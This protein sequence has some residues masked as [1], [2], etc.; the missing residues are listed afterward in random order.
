MERWERSGKAEAGT[1]PRSKRSGKAEVG[2]VPRS[3]RVASSQL[4]CW[5]S[6]GEKGSGKGFGIEIRLGAWR[7]KGRSHVLK[8]RTEGNWEGMVASL[9]CL[10][11]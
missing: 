3:K 1:V 8:K 4:R 5:T 2:T 9:S 7:S 10:V 6:Q 11:P